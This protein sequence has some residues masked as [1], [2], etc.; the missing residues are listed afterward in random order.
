MRVPMSHFSLG[1]V[2]WKSPILI[3]ELRVS[4]SLS[5]EWWSQG[6]DEVD[7][8]AVI[9]YRNRRSKDKLPI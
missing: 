4:Q 9:A 5:M 2:Y 3:W 8:K 7:S 6:A 1:R